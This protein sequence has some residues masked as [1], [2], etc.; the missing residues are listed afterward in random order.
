MSGAAAAAARV[1]W[2]SSP[3][4]SLVYDVGLCG[5]WYLV[6]TIGL[7]SNIEFLGYLCWVLSSVDETAESLTTQGTLAKVDR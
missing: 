5:L 7:R 1:Q 2:Q 4:L 3:S 6:G